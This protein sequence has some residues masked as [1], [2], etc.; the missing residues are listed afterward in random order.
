[1]SKFDKLQRVPFENEE[2]DIDYPEIK[3]SNFRF[4]NNFLKR[5]CSVLQSVNGTY[6]YKFEDQMNQNGMRKLINMVHG[7]LFMIEHEDVEPDQAYGTLYDIRDFETGEY[8]DLFT[9]EDLRLLKEDIAIVKNY[10]WDH[11]ELLRYDWVK[12]IRDWFFEAE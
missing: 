5:G 2:G 8:D 7:M 10:V 11:P 1:M 9:K 6:Y 3:R 4:F 12:D